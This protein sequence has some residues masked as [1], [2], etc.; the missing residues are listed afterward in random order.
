MSTVEGE[1]PRK[2]PDTAE[3][4]VREKLQ[5]ASI[6]A[7]AQNDQDDN[8]TTSL[9]AD[10]TVESAL[11]KGGAA[12]ETTTTAKDKTDAPTGPA[13]VTRGR[14]QRKRSFD[15]SEG[16]PQLVSG[17]RQGRKRSRDSTLDRDEDAGH[18]ISGRTSEESARDADADNGG[19]ANGGT[20]TEL[21]TSGG[22]TPTDEVADVTE[23]DTSPKTKRSRVG[24][25]ENDATVAVEGTEEDKHSVVVNGTAKPTTSKEEQSATKADSA[26]SKSTTNKPA[27]TSASAFASSGFGAFASS[28]SSGFGSVSEGKK[29]SSFASPEPET[30]SATASKP[31]T[32]TFGGA[33]GQTSAFGGGSASGFGS[34]S[35]GGF[36]S[37]FGGSG[38]GFGSA[39]GG[40]GGT[41]LSSFA[42]S[43][44]AAPAGVKKPVKAFGAP[45]DAE[46][47]ASEDDGEEEDGA[48]LKSPKS[49]EEEKQDERFFRQDLNT[50]EE[51]EK[52][53]YTCRAKL[54][55]FVHSNPDDETSKKEWKE[56]GLGTL[57]LNV[58]NS[59]NEEADL[60]AGRSGTPSGGAQARLVMRADGSHRV[61]LNT[62]IKKELRF[63]S[64]TGDAPQN[65]YVYFMGSIDGRPKLELLQLKVCC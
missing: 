16:A 61:I 17:S 2:S 30:K 44:N 21:K 12:V 28:S 51:N 63:G 56:R 29:L 22:T 57:R 40:V 35:S 36:G 33:L 58:L 43:S 39:F 20:H 60:E 13:A 7:T 9:I 34:S 4:P 65:G 55:N 14:T 46:D 10:T 32:S 18:N 47:E 31:S 59:G 6:D 54:Y 5:K 27:Q 45:A 53:E 3:K 41:K 38:G 52:T 25:K 19:D 64:V 48:R 42:T 26:E 24:D 1:V 49:N 23:K 8:G 11:K 37:A 62:P 50:G 15:E